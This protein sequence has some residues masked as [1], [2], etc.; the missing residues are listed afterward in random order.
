M[1]K[2]K[3]YYAIIFMMII[4]GLWELLVRLFKINSHILPPPSSI[5]SCL[6]DNLA[7]LLSHSLVTLAESVVGLIISILLSIILGMILDQSKII[8]NCLYPHLI[9]T[10]MIP[11]MVLGPLFTMWFGFGYLPKILMVIMMCFFPMIITFYDALQ[12]CNQEMIHLLKSYG[13]SKLQVYRYVKI[14][15]AL[16]AF[17]SSVK[18]SATYCVSGAIVGEWL[19][20]S[21]G[22][23]YYMIRA[24]NG[25]MMD[26]VFA[27]IVMIILLSLLLNLVVSVV[28]K[29]IIPYQK[30]G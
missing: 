3:R 24:K 25:F 26:K 15:Y 4:L 6:I 23:G 18:V 12:Q 27:C 1:K 10:Q 28:E 21:C 8:K 13:A 7:V 22:L 2:E 30:K 5:I 20:S 16:P 19:N 14:P 9:I 11:V 29:I 17:I